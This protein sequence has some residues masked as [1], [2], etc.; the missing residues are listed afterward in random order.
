MVMAGRARCRYCQE[1]D[2]GRLWAEG[3]RARHIGVRGCRL[4]VT[5]LSPGSIRSC[6]WNPDIM[7]CLEG[8]CVMCVQLARVCSSSGCCCGRARLLHHPTALLSLSAMQACLFLPAH[9]ALPA[10]CCSLHDTRYAAPMPLCR[11][12]HKARMATRL[13]P[14][15]PAASQPAGARQ[16]R[17]SAAARAAAASSGS[18]CCPR[19][20]TPR[21]G[22]AARA[23]PPLR[24]Q[25][26]AMRRKHKRLLQHMRRVLHASTCSRR[27]RMVLR[28]VTEDAVLRVQQHRGAAWARQA[29]G[30]RR[31]EPSGTGPHAG[32]LQGMRSAAGLLCAAAASWLHARPGADGSP[33]GATAATAAT[34][35]E[36]WP[37]AAPV[38][39]GAPACY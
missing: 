38:A 39:S 30:A 7:P 14:R 25:R 5:A 10:S 16:R 19:C 18:A 1:R 23:S 37:A 2:A 28:T 27:R 9:P 13:P 3:M 35:A 32:W 6:S 29:A 4:R 8:E 24:P 21:R 36:A 34:A 15:R 26:H 12:A 31:A 33:F 17:V 11:P 20:C 22:A